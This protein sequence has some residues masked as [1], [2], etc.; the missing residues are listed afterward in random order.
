VRYRLLIV[1]L[2][3]SSQGFSQNPE[4]ND[5]DN[6]R[7]RTEY[8]LN[9]FSKIDSDTIS[10]NKIKLFINK[11]EQKKEG[12]RNDHDFLKYLFTKTHQ[13][14]LRNY[15]EYCSFNEVLNDGTYNCL[16]G[17]A[18]YAILLDHFNFS[19]KIIETN[20]HIFL[21]AKTS[22]GDILFEST[23]PL[24]GFVDTKE[25]IKQ[26]I[27]TFLDNEVQIKTGDEVNFR[28]SFNIY[29]EVTIEQLQGL[30]YYNFSINAYNK[31]DLMASINFL[32]KASLYYQSKRIE[33]FSKVIL[34]TIEQGKI[35][36]NEKEICLQKINSLRQKMPVVASKNPKL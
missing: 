1:V 36:N 12:F 33:A 24:S 9:L 6:S 17:T 31:K 14:I 20:Y 3:F 34:L 16:T 28:Y 22:Q 32:D 10:A 8:Y 35:N 11:I 13:K 5:T 25:K 27:N 30:L 19:F 15:A 18:L 29:D 4:L 23:D 21:I 7:T 26:R 2:F